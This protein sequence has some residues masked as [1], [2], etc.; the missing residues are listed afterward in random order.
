MTERRVPAVNHAK[1]FDLAT[2]VVSA[3][4]QLAFF[5][6]RS[7]VV[8]PDS[9]RASVTTSNRNLFVI[10]T[11]TNTVVGSPITLGTPNGALH[12]VAIAPDG[13]FVY[14]AVGGFDRTVL[15]IDTATST[16]A[17]TIPIVGGSPFNLGVTPDG[18][19]NHSL[20]YKANRN[21]SSTGVHSGHMGNVFVRD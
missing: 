5:S 21:H 20:A 6:T 12:G 2:N 4:I 8:S 13:K 7:V 3:S 10:D 16:V 9:T 1:R 17:A 19:S 15:V 14:V 18:T 11:V